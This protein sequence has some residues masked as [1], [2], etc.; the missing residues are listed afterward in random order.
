MLDGKYALIRDEQTYVIRAFPGKKAYAFTASAI[1]SVYSPHP[2]LLLSYPKQVRCTV[3]RQ[4]A[5]AN[6]KIIASLQLHHPERVCA[7]TLTD[8]SVGGLSCIVKEPIGVKNNVVTIKFKIRA[9]GTDE[10]LSLPFILRSIIPIEDT[11]SFRYG[12]EFTD[13][14]TQQRLILSA[15]VHQTIAEAD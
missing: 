7:A 8:L 4:G 10:F 1:K 6:V 13:L 2:Y 3:I 15:F 12:I 14:L 5:R 9:V 11:S